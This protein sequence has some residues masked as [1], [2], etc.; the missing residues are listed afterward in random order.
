MW[1]NHLKQSTVLTHIRPLVG[2]T[3]GQSVQGFFDKLETLNLGYYAVSC[4][5]KTF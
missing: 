1:L 2:E 3:L 4:H 5:L